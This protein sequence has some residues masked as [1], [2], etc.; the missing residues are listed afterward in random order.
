MVVK[1]SEREREM[2]RERKERETSI[3][4]NTE[5]SLNLSWFG[6]GIRVRE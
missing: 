6:R 3:I 2:R 4:G 5:K 1:A